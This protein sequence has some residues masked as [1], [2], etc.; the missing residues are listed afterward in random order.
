MLRELLRGRLVFTPR[1]DGRAVE[2]VG[3]GDYGRLFVGLI[4]L[5]VP[6]ALASQAALSW[7]QVVVFLRDL[8]RL[9]AA[10]IT[11]A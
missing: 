2:F 8:N 6:Q 5:P 10:G 3:R 9:R 11:A 7:N 1:D 4:G